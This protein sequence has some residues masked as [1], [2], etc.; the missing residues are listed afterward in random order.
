MNR[1]DEYYST[2]DNSLS[3]VGEYFQHLYLIASH[4]NS[5]NGAKSEVRLPYETYLYGTKFGDF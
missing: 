2:Y 3:F 1:T 5:R 4:A